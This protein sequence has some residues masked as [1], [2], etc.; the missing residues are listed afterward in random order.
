[1]KTVTLEI[2]ADETEKNAIAEKLMKAVGYKA[3]VKSMSDKSYLEFSSVDCDGAHESVLVEISCGVYTF[4]INDQGA[5][6]RAELD[7]HYNNLEKRTKPA[8]YIEEVEFDAWVEPSGR[9][10]GS[11]FLPCELCINKGSL[12]FENVDIELTQGF[13]YEMKRKGTLLTHLKVKPR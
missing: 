8:P 5:L 2:F 1:M 11:N 6:A 9:I 3:E 4:R 12:T 10:T 13:V 7:F